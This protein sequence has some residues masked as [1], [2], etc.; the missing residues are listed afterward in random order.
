[1]AYG[2]SGIIVVVE[3]EDLAPRTE[4]LARL[5]GAGMALPQ[6]LR[7]EFPRN[8]PALYTGVAKE[9][10]QLLSGDSNKLLGVTHGNSG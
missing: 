7:T 1:M 5:L 8:D 3:R 10:S 6:Q 9:F 4:G 2:N